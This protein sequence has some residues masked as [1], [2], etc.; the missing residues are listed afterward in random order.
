V[1]WP[2]G[3]YFLSEIDLLLKNSHVRK[4]NYLCSS[5]C[6]Q[7]GWTGKKRGVKLGDTLQEESRHSGR[8]LWLQ[9]QN[10]RR[11]LKASPRKNTKEKWVLYP[12]EIHHDEASLRYSRV[13]VTIC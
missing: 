3:T 8:K 2:V 4:K 9:V 7:D 13:V 11:T 5:P 12:A 6:G 1:Y 10:G